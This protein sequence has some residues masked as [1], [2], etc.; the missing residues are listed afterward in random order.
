MTGKPG[1]AVFWHSNTP[2]ASDWNRSE[3]G[4]LA[5][6]VC[7]NAMSNNPGEGRGHGLP[8]PVELAPEDA[9]IQ[10]KHAQGIG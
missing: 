6:I 7:Y 3:Y 2:H 10:W 1:G 4:R 5:I 9:L 8:I